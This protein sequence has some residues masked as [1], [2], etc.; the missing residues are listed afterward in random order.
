V[1]RKLKSFPGRRAT[2]RAY[3]WEQWLDGS[4]WLLR[5]GEDYSI[6]TDSMRAAVS[7][8]AKQAG[9]RARTSVVEDDDGTE[10]LAV[11]AY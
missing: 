5:S 4:V 8:A 1:A 9:K 2:S 11:Q 7:R 3:P 6:T 10:A